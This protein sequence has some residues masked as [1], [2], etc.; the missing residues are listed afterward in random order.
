MLH[1]FVCDFFN[2]STLFIV[3]SQ[4]VYVST[5][6]IFKDSRLF[7]ENHTEMQ[8]GFTV[9]NVHCKLVLHPIFKVLIARYCKLT[10]EKVKAQWSVTIATSGVS[11]S[12]FT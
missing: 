6:R 3:L 10:Y 1:E 8:S 11:L 12:R 4:N 5:F 9:Q 7:Y 2:I